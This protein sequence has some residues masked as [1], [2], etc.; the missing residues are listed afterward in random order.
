MVLLHESDML[1]AYVPMLG[2]RGFEAGSSLLPRTLYGET[3]CHHI[4]PPAFDK[5]DAQLVAGK[6]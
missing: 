5:G 4:T 6:F 3:I 1:L 2:T